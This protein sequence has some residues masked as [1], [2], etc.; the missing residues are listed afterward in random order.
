MD[1]KKFDFPLPSEEEIRIVK[2]IARF[3][4]AELD[5]RDRWVLRE[6]LGGD[7]K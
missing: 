6:F 3:A 2:E 1:F 5:G 7:F 4:P